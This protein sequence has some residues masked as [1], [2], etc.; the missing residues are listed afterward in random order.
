MNYL[1][2]QDM[3]S[4]SRVHRGR[5][6]RITHAAVLGHYFFRVR[7]YLDGNL[8][9][10]TRNPGFAGTP[11]RAFMHLPYVPDD[12]GYDPQ[13]DFA[14]ANVG[15]FILHACLAAALFQNNPQHFFSTVM[16]TP[17]ACM[18]QRD[19]RWYA[20]TSLP[21]AIDATCSVQHRRLSQ[22]GRLSSRPP[23]IVVFLS[24]HITL[25]LDRTLG[26]ELKNGQRLRPAP[27]WPKKPRRQTCRIAQ[28]AHWPCG[29]EPYLH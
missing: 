8:M 21:R 7:E 3:E 26:F 10:T 14:Y 17:A 5:N 20:C 12:R 13:L 2:R 18:S 1:G 4:L 22:R 27:H 11:G 28:N 6:T 9:A 25:S 19:I 15:H 24:R 29:P 16:A 23:S